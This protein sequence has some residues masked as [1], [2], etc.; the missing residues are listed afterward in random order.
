MPSVKKNYLYQVSYEL[1]AILIPLITAPYVARVLGADKLGIFTYTFAIA[2]VYFV[3]ARLGIVNHGSRS[4][5]A[6]QD[7]KDERSRVFWEIYAVQ[8]IAAVITTVAYCLFV[9]I[10]VAE[11]KSIAL[12]QTIFVVSSLFDIGWFFIGIENFRKIVIRNTIVKILSLVLIFLFVKSIS[13]LW[14][15]TI[16]ITGGTLGGHLILW[17]G[18]KKQISWVC[19]SSAAIKKQLKPI[20]ILFIPAIAVTIYTIIDKVMLGIM[21]GPTEVAY[22]EYAAK[23]AG[24]PL[25]FITS[26]GLVMLPRMSALA[27]KNKDSESSNI[28]HKSLVFVMFLSCSFTFGLAAIS[29]DLIPIFY[30]SEFLP[31]I[32][33]LILISIKLPFMAWANVIRTQC[34]IPN[35]R[36]REYLVS[37]YVGAAV[38]LILN[39]ILIPLYA[40]YGAAL[41]T[42][43]AEVSVCIV[44]TC[45]T[46]SQV[47]PLKPAIKS[48]GFIIIGII[49]YIVVRL[50]SNNIGEMSILGLVF[51]IFC[52]AVVY[53]FLSFI[54]YCV[55]LRRKRPSEV[56]KSVSLSLK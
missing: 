46:R 18:L 21:S 8:F 13:D 5:A 33:L 16:I 28:I 34:L 36:D 42:I 55:I 49:M 31:C 39:L 23:L 45:F 32:P 44:Q 40:A 7:D 2:S 51:E 29:D 43:A 47:N 12:L 11:N 35:H 26:F 4:I 24:V 19:P 1:L 14:L 27:A 22:Y 53:L 56:L 10:F 15:Y 48:S 17:I 52:G 37:L 25:G 3:V 50:I 9:I 54:F 38:N 41:A 6:E 20:T 30:G